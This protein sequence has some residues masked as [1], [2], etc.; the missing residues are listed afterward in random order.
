M[1]KLSLTSS[2]VVFSIQNGRYVDHRFSCS[3]IQ[4]VLSSN[5]HRTLSILGNCYILSAGILC[6]G[7]RLRQD[8]AGDPV[9]Q[10]LSCPS[11]YLL[12][13]QALQ[14]YS[15]ESLHCSQLY[16]VLFM[17]GGKERFY[18]FSMV[19]TSIIT[20][21]HITPSF[22][23]VPICPCCYLYTTSSKSVPCLD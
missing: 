18:I 20:F 16:L 1:S 14:L 12:L 3:S 13:A 9:G 22:L 19:A 17:M 5:E 15:Y 2:S 11:P 23:P 6:S 4:G 8:F 10:G 7:G 21:V